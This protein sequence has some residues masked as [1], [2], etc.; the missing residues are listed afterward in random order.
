M[1][2]ITHYFI[3]FVYTLQ[4]IQYSDF[5]VNV[6]GENIGKPAALD[7]KNTTVTYVSILGVEG[8][9]QRLKEFRQQTLKLIDECWPSGAETIKDVVNYIVDRKN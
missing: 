2:T 7:I 9:R 5:D 8:T 3:Y 6:E 4:N 1:V